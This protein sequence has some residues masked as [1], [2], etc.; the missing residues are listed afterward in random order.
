MT[1]LKW[2]P[3]SGRVHVLLLVLNFA[4]FMFCLNT[5]HYDYLLVS[6]L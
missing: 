6:M 5:N 2:R 3:N 4:I 1:S